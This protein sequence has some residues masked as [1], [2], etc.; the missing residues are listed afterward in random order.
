MGQD[1][2]WRDKRV[3]PRARGDSTLGSTVCFGDERVNGIWMFRE[4]EVPVAASLSIPK[5]VLNITN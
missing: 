1:S 3:A 4:V 5:A 2:L